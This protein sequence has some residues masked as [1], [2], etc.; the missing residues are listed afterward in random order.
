MVKL[1]ILFLSLVGVKNPGTS[2]TAVWLLGSLLIFGLMFMLSLSFIDRADKF[3]FGSYE[4]DEEGRSNPEMKS[5]RKGNQSCLFLIAMVVF[6]IYL[7]LVIGSHLL[8]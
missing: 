4:V 7:S 8:N 3:L 5:V 6:Q 2:E 1:I